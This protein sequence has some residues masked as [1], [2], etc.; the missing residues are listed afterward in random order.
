MAYVG[1]I[2]M[3]RGVMYCTHGPSGMVIYMY[4]DTPG[5][6]FD[7]H[8]QPVPETLAKDAGFNTEKYAKQRKRNAEMAKVMKVLDSEMAIDDSRQIHAEKNGYRLISL[9]SGLA[10]VET[11]EGRLT[12]TPIPL[13]TAVIIFNKLVGED[14]AKTGEPPKAKPQP[15]SPTKP[16]GGGPGDKTGGGGPK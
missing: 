11:D 7:A 15:Q 13:G 8:T 6:Y 1:P 4:I 5:E 10:Y 3:D 2:D 9:E 16:A 12:P 14:E